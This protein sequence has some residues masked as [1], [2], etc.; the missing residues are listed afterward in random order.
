MEVLTK[1]LCWFSVLRRLNDSTTEEFVLQLTRSTSEKPKS[2]RFLFLQYNYMV[3]RI[4]NIRVKTLA[5]A[6][7][8]QNQ[9]CYETNGGWD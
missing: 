2:V 8:N 4:Y 9:S 3:I 1:E 5:F 7:F 6:T